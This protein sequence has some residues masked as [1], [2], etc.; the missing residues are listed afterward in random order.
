MSTVWA[1]D[2]EKLAAVV[3]S[4]KGLRGVSYQDISRETGVNF[5]QIASFTSTGTGVGLN[6]LVSLAMWS[7]A[8]IRSFVVR[9]RNASRHTVSPQERELRSLAKYLEAAGL[10]K[11]DNES[12]VEA[13]IRL[14][15]L[16]KEQG[17]DFT[18]GDD[19]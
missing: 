3:K 4:E 19:D 15:A 12:P 14:L 18:D 1:F 6:G 5:T 2:G 10:A 8:D 17:A 13:A 11:V 7:N 9:K 16:A